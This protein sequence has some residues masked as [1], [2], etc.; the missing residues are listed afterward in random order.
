MSKRY[1][2]KKRGGATT[3]SFVDKDLLKIFREKNRE[4]NIEKIYI[5]ILK[6]IGGNNIDDTIYNTYIQ[7][8]TNKDNL[9]NIKNA[10]SKKS[11]NILFCIIYFICRQY[12]EFHL[13]T[14][15]GSPV[16]SFSDNKP[17]TYG[18]ININNIIKRVPINISTITTINHPFIYNLT[19]TQLNQAKYMSYINSFISYIIE[20]RQTK[21]YDDLFLL[22]YCC[23][24]LNTKVYIKPHVLSKG[25]KTEPMK[26]YNETLQEIFN[27]FNKSTLLNRYVI[28]TFN[29]LIKNIHNDLIYNFSPYNIF[30]KYLN[31]HPI[32][33]LKN[34]G[35]MQ[36][37]ILLYSTTYTHL[38]NEI[39]TIDLT[40]NNTFD[41]TDS[42]Q[43]IIESSSTHPLTFKNDIKLKSLM[44][45]I[46]S[47]LLFLYD[48][49][50][51]Q[52]EQHESGFLRPRATRPSPP[53]IPLLNKYEPF[54]KTNDY[55]QL[56]QTINT[57]YGLG[58]NF[59][60]L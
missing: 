19:I 52:T 31:E 8:K 32:N 34:V 9:I 53:T 24:I 58:I 2:L 23:I 21:L 18:T 22:Y 36:I 59:E 13:D 14:P 48:P 33:A 60:E 50:H 17:I 15:S 30:N 46:Q 51:P 28:P 11:I 47:Y 26:S 3:D 56:A 41:K 6:Y 20:T 54:F 29:N 1:T 40:K 55:T 39:L 37:C 44:D 5:E 12:V 16:S 27:D 43:D 42:L 35:I 45:P 25:N 7:T 38:Q 10:S 57:L 49:K 4:I